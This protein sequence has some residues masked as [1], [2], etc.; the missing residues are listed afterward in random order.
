MGV[1]MTKNEFLKELKSHL[2]NISGDEQNIIIE[3]YSEIINDKLDDG[4]NEEEIISELGSPKKIALTVTKDYYERE[5]QD[6]RKSTT[7]NKNFRQAVKEYEYDGINS[8]NID[9]M[10]SDII[11]KASCNNNIKITYYT[12]ECFPKTIENINGNITLKNVFFPFKDTLK[13]IAKNFLYLWKKH[14]LKTI[15]EIPVECTNLKFNLHTSNAK[16]FIQNIKAEKLNIKT[17]NG[18]INTSNLYGN[19]IFLHTS[20]SNLTIKST[21]AETVT[22]ET[23]NGKI[24]VS[25]IVNTKFLKLVTLNGSITVNNIYVETLETKTSNGKIHITDIKSQN[26]LSAKTSNGLINITDILSDNI[27]LITS[28]GKINGNIVGNPNDYNISSKTSNADNSL[29]SYNYKNQ[30]SYKTLLANTS[31]GRI[32]IIF[33]E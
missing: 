25:D 21:N 15:I 22:A 7:I 12:N 5:N 9:I 32:S 28:N 8:I 30:T 33:T 29:S 26:R 27:S 1:N 14:N 31:N 24:T 13:Q 23:S 17:S 10:N 2:S 19:E 4:Q 3:Y 6:Y 18:K 11:L 20:N 16:I